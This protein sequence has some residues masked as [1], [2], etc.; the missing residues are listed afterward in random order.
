MEE[1]VHS[2]QYDIIKTPSPRRKESVSN[3]DAKTQQ[4]LRQIDTVYRLQD[5]AEGLMTKIYKLRKLLDNPGVGYQ[6]SESFWN[7]GIFP[8]IPKL[9][10]YIGKKFPEHTSKLQLEKVNLVF[11]V[12]RQLDSYHK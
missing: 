9:C 10:V 6:F 11:D 8:D 2:Y 12:V 3:Q 4:K 1:F 7:A 5:A